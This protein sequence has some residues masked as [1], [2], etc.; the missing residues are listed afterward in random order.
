[1]EMPTVKE[2]GEYYQ[3]NSDVRNLIKYIAG[4]CAGKE[5]VRYCNGRGL[6]KDSK[7]A[8]DKLIW[9]QKYYNK[10]NKRRLYHFIVSFDETVDDPNCIKMVAEALAEKFFEKSQVYYG[11]HED[12]DNLHIHFAVNSVSYRDGKKWHMNKREFSVFCR[13]LKEIA[14]EVLEETL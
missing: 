9:V 14:Y 6:P 5:K 2:V 4:D 1:M 12:S 11:V 3:K 13:E 7:M 10:D 8:A